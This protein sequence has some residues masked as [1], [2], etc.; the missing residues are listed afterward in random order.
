L[1][2]GLPAAD[3]ARVMGRRPDAVR[4]LQHRALSALR[5]SLCEESR[6]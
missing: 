4:Q 6:R 3:V 5:A 2:D 1:I